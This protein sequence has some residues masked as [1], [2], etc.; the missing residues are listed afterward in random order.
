MSE[1]TDVAAGQYTRADLQGKDVVRGSVSPRMFDRKIHAVLLAIILLFAAA[2]RIHGLSRNS[3]WFDECATLDIVRTPWPKVLHQIMG[4]ENTPPGYYIFLK[5]F[6]DLFGTSECALRLPSALAGIASI[7]FLYRLCSYSIGAREGLIAAALMSASR[8]HIWYSQEARLHVYA[9]AGVWSCD[10]FVRML[11]EPPKWARELRYWIATVLLLYSHI[12]AVFALAA[13]VIYYLSRYI[14]HDKPLLKPTR[15]AQLQLAIWI[16][17]AMWFPVLWHWYKMRSD[18]FWIA[19]VTLGQIGLSYSVYLRNLSA[20]T[21]FAVAA[22]VVMGCLRRDLRRW[23]ALFLPLLL[24][25]VVI[26]VIASMLSHPLFTPR[27]GIV[28][29]VGL[30][31]LAACGVARLPKLAQPIVVL[32]L[33]AALLTA[34]TPMDKYDALARPGTGTLGPFR[35]VGAYIR[36]W[37]QPNDYVWVNPKA[38][39]GSTA[40]L[41][42]AQRHHLSRIL[43]SAFAAWRANDSPAKSRLA[44]ADQSGPIGQRHTNDQLRSLARGFAKALRSRRHFRTR[45]WRHQRRRNLSRRHSLQR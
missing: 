27:Y 16:P 13:Q 31:A 37:A 28:A 20:L 2:V 38:D 22:L 23:L 19:D 36:Q 41:R 25:P 42:R 26:P 7:W 43:G 44:R 10:E 8:F 21:L 1:T 39:I 34:P 9:D 30:F 24:L 45:R 35:E 33:A 29:L 5:G 12:Y 4:S 3:L 6:C 18:G 17:F 15:L 14:R 11:D 32:L 40:L